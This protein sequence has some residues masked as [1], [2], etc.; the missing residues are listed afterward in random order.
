MS[1]TRYQFIFF[2]TLQTN[3]SYFIIYFIKTTEYQKLTREEA[4]YT[5]EKPYDTHRSEIRKVRSEDKS[6][7]NHE[8]KARQI[9]RQNPI[10]QKEN[11]C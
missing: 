7:K 11:I 5:K 10:N 1:V 6:L 4:I 9:N 2:F 3:L 8:R